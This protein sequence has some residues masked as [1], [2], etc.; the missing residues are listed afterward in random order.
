M[1]R[2]SSKD[3]S[4]AGTTRTAPISFNILALSLP[5]TVIWVLIWSGSWGNCLRR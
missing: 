3:S 1:A 2:I 5:V 4:L